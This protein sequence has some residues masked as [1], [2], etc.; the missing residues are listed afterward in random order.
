MIAASLLGAS[1]W[2]L[3]ALALSLAANAVLAVLYARADGKRDV[4][5]VTGTVCRDANAGNVTTLGVLRD[6]LG[7]AQATCRVYA[8]KVD[9]V[10]RDRETT[11]AAIAAEERR[12]AAEAEE[13]YAN[14]ADCAA[15]RRVPVCDAL[16][17][18]LRARAARP[19]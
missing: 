19:D 16:A 5:E 8:D 4:A 15:L 6:A 1:R 11:R 18:G 10:A 9:Q 14:D 7:A 2:L 3:G 17:R 12:R 13:S